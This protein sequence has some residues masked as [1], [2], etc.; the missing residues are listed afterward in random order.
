M[1]FVSCGVLERMRIQFD[2]HKQDF[3]RRDHGVRRQLRLAVKVACIHSA[4]VM[5]FVE[6]LPCSTSAG[7]IGK[8]SQLLPWLT[9][10]CPRWGTS[11]SVP[12]ELGPFLSSF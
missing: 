1:M 4:L 12:G 10:F 6:R 11:C 9:R 7:R 2:N 3:G 8:P 5:V